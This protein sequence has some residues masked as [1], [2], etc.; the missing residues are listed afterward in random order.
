MDIKWL[1][2]SCFVLTSNS[3]VRLLM[4]P[5]DPQV[6]YSLEPVEVDG[7]TCSHDH[8][9]HNYV[10]LAKG[11][12]AQ[13]ITGPGEFSIGDVKITGFPSWHDDQQ[14]ALRGKNI[15]YLVE[16]DGLR[17]L[18]AGDLGHIPAPSTLDALGRIDI[19]LVP[20]GG[21]YTLDYNQALEVCRLLQPGVVIPM[22]YKTE[23]LKI[24]R[25]DLAPFL[26]SADKRWKIHRMR[27]SDAVLTPE[28]LGKNRIIVL[29]YAG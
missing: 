9:D 18:H 7:V 16:M 11:G 6:G 2:H 20:V 22:H 28:S 24:S 12:H 15:M 19:L 26:N 8:Y 29:D 3:G 21:V 14:G 27:Q 25:G 23:P 13:I 1:G 10:A 5:C 17:L 4:D